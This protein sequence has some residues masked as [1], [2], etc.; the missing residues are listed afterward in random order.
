[1]TKRQYTGPFI[2][3]LHLIALII[4]HL[5]GYVGHYG[6]DDMQYAEMANNLSQ[7]NIDFQDHFSFRIT[8]LS[9]TALSYSL[10]GISDFSSSLPTILVTASILFMV[11]DIVKDKSWII[12]SSALSLCLFSPWFLQY[13][14]KLMPDMY[15]AAAV[16]Y[17]VFIY[18]RYAYQKQRNNK[19]KFSL[20]FAAS[21]MLG[22]CSKGTIVLIVP[23]LIYLFL[24]DYFKNKDRT[25]Y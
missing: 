3:G 22:F 18:H 9:L 1:M 21:L 24:L 17:S 25:Y 7:G 13:S 23:W 2:L 12:I 14:D 10:F 6:F 11:Y 19:I 5:F 16:M 8:I 20:L 15:L 4:F